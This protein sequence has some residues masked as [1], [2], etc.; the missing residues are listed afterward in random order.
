[1]N[2]EIDKKL[3]NIIKEECEDYFALLEQQLLEEDN[4]DSLIQQSD[5]HLNTCEECAL[6]NEA[7]SILSEEPPISD[8][9]AKRAVETHF[10]RQKNR[11]IKRFG[12]IGLAAAAAFAGF[13]IVTTTTEPK[14]I[15]PDSVAKELV[16][17]PLYLTLVS[18]SADIDGATAHKN[19]T[20]GEG[21]RLKA[22]NEQVLTSLGDL[23]TMG[24]EPGTLINFDE[25]SQNRMIL[26]IERGSIAARL[27]PGAKTT[28]SVNA[29]AVE[30]T[31]TGTI[32]GVEFDREVVNVSVVRGSVKVS[33]AQW[34]EASYDVPAGWS[35][36]SS[37]Q[38]VHQLKDENRSDLLSLLHLAKQNKVEHLIASEEPEG[39]EAIEDT[40]ETSL[41]NTKNISK[42]HAFKSKPR[43]ISATA[44]RK[45]DGAN[46][47]HPQ[48][49]Q[50]LIQVARECRKQRKWKCA[51][52]AYE[53]VTQLYPTHREAKTV[54][55]S[56]AEIRLDYLNQPQ[57]ALSAYELYLFT[58][59]EGPL[60]QEA[61]YGKIK[62]LSALGKKGGEENAL[63]VFLKKYPT[64]VHAPNARNRL[65]ELEQ[66]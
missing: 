16:A 20:I 66:K 55:L 10:N 8:E 59:P 32:F 46:E 22:K 7:I 50:E 14:P 18:G 41:T 52:S 45:I 3:N 39:E 26:D 15:K 65:K 63:R 12:W 54:L 9:I 29:K 5:P 38:S 21:Q 13:V 33:S 6:F 48:T 27:Q 64:S 31:V 4:E 49:L 61:L 57:K 58:T 37:D 51:E 44:P 43:V 30:V 28:L 40:M 23:F 1:M 35:F 36:S 19:A 34:G 47:Q 24:L 11:R 17:K 25:L 62:S 60:A 2:N 56:L 42:H 53:K